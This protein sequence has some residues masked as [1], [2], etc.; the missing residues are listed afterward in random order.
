MKT[1]NY[2]SNKSPCV[3]KLSGNG[4]VG[5]TLSVLFVCFVQMISFQMLNI[6]QLDQMSYVE[7]LYVNLNF[8]RLHVTLM[9]QISV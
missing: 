1:E 7:L 6:L 4:Y 9:M 2:V 5:S 8:I 3:T